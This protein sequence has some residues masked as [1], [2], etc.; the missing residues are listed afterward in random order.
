MLDTTANA[1]DTLINTSIAAGSVTRSDRDEST[2][3]LSSC[4]ILLPIHLT[5]SP[6]RAE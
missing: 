3:R 2:V 1:L 4:S 6:T 5:H